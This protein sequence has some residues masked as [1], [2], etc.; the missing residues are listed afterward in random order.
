MPR[1]IVPAF[2]IVSGDSLEMAEQRAAILAERGHAYLDEV[3]PIQ[4][5]PEDYQ[6]ADGLPT[7]TLLPAHR[8]RPRRAGGVV[9]WCKLCHVGRSLSP[10]GI[11]Q[12]CTWATPTE[13]AAKR[14]ARADRRNTRTR[15]PRA[16]AVVYLAGAKQE[17]LGIKW[18][19]EGGRRDDERWRG[20]VH[21]S[22]LA[23]A[24]E[25]TSKAAPLP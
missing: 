2:F 6:G 9:S 25:S 7:P 14:D 18:A 15:A 19:T 23:G 4:A 13:K 20:G 1:Y 5:I 8:L 21:A 24:R 22:C 16:L 3:H 10:G 11:C 17:R 12:R